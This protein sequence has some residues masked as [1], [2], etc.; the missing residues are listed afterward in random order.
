MKRI[1]SYKKE[2]PLEDERYGRQSIASNEDISEELEKICVWMPDKTSIDTSNL[3]IP[4]T[5]VLHDGKSFARIGVDGRCIDD[6]Y[7][8]K[9]EIEIMP[10]T[11]ELPKELSDLLSKYKFKKSK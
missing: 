9:V 2:Y 6:K 7:A 1:E 3:R 11:A 8:E 10:E 4:K 5:F